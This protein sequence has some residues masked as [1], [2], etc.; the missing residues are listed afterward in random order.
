MTKLSDT[1]VDDIIR[2]RAKKATVKQLAQEY[3]VSRQ[4][5]DNI[6]SGRRGNRDRRRRNLLMT[7]P[8]QQA[9]RF[10]HVYTTLNGFP[11]S[12]QEI[13]AASG[14]NSKSVTTARLRLLRE[15]GVITYLDDRPRT[16]RVCQPAPVDP[17]ILAA[18][19]RIEER[20]EQLREAQEDLQKVIAALFSPALSADNKDV[21]R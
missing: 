1:Q 13:G 3:G 17:R 21:T 8:Y 4:T 12:L 6:V 11:P 5:I 9:V 2:R 16:Y 15:F 20:Q 14:T 19:A 10:I 7:P 18:V